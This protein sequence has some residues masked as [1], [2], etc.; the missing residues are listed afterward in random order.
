[1]AYTIYTSES[2]SFYNVTTI[3]SPTGLCTTCPTP[4][5]LNSPND[6]PKHM[7]SRRALRHHILLLWFQ[8]VGAQFLTHCSDN[9]VSLFHCVAIFVKWLHYISNGKRGAYVLTSHQRHTNLISQ[10]NGVQCVDWVVVWTAQP[11]CWLHSSQCLAWLYNL[12][13][14]HITMW[15]I[16]F[17]VQHT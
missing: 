13:C 10:G 6:S 2:W 4:H 11:L 14:Q 8:C 5:P 12:A 1:M 9:L 7:V 3:G 17:T 16:T 15:A